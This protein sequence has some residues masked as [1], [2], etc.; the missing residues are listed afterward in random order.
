MRRIFAGIGCAMLLAGHAW[1]APN[2]IT[3]R[4][5]GMTCPACPITIKKTLLKQPGIT[6]VNVMYA[7]KELVVK[8]DD[9]KIS[10]AAIMKSTASVGFPSQI[11]K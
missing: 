2:S 3:L 11:A 6:A 8:F 1:A 5:P 9:G 7:K 10:P 4:V